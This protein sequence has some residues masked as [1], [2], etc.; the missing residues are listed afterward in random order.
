MRIS[1]LERTEKLLQE[2]EFRALQSQINPHFLFNSLTVI[3]SICRTEPS[4]ARDLIYSLSRH[5]RKNLNNTA[6]LVSIWEEIDHVEAYVSI[7]KARLNEDL[8]VIYKIDQSLNFKIPPLT[9]Q[10]IVENAVKHGIYPKKG[11]GIIHLSIHN[12]D[13]A[14]VISIADDGVGMDKNVANG[15]LNGQQITSSHGTRNVIERLKTAYGESFT[16][17]I[18]S[19]VNRGTKILFKFRKVAQN[20]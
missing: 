16:M 10:P 12:H 1:K 17:D 11:K 7:E 15:I 6:N 20:V 13:K 2:A 19:E 18:Q 8:C 3:G 14:V 5:F 9:L 4:K